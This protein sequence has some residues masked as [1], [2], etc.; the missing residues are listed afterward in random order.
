MSQ[1]P[2][3]CHVWSLMTLQFWFA[4]LSQVLVQDFQG[5]EGISV[6][7]GLYLTESD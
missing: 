1:H 2:G 4:G 6:T 7:C 3:A 5:R